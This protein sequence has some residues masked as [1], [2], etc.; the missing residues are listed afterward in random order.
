MGAGYLQTSL[1]PSLELLGENP[2][3]GF[4]TFS[5]V[6]ILGLCRELLHLLK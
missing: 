4:V 6:P 2:Y 3:L 5:L 1:A